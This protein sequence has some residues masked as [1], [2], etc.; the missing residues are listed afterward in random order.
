E[1]SGEGAPAGSADDVL[2]L[3]RARQRFQLELVGILR[4][5]R[6]G[7]RMRTLARLFRSLGERDWGGGQRLLWDTSGTLC[8]AVAMDGLACEDRVRSCLREIDNEL[9][10]FIALEAAFRS[11]A[12]SDS[13][14][15]ALL[16][17]LADSRPVSGPVVAL[18]QK[19]RLIPGP[20]LAESDGGAAT[21]RE[22]ANIAAISRELGR[23]FERVEGSGGDS[24]AIDTVLR[25]LHPDLS[26]IHGMLVAGEFTP[27]ATALGAEL[28]R[29]GTALSPG[30]DQEER[31]TEI[32]M[33]LLE[34]DQRLAA[35]AV[36]A[37][38]PEAASDARRHPL[39]LARETVCREVQAG[40]EQAKQAVADYARSGEAATALTALP[41]ILG[42]LVGALRLTGLGG[43]ESILSACRA[44][45][46]DVLAGRCAAPDSADVDR[47]ADGLSS[48]EYFLERLLQ[49]GEPSDLIL[50]RSRESIGCLGQGVIAIPPRGIARTPA[51]PEPLVPEPLVPAP[52]P[53]E[54]ALPELEA[55]LPE[56]AGELPAEY[57]IEE[58]FDE[59]AAEAIRVEPEA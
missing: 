50:A 31:L 47:L 2:L 33:T 17:A 5:D 38:S 16:T 36:R 6:V 54:E 9:R 52:Q 24:G 58:L 8:E 35:R 48:V 40:I 1:G 10:A 57:P 30:M 59:P 44:Y 42:G 56:L 21:V 25:E 23:I 27:E 39:V 53:A 13:L 49:D 11:R 22:I 18:Q 41:A 43:A 55:E 46:G 34:V 32:T 51:V 7:E 15:R 26:Q 20:G 45:L 14:Y 12:P 28:T 29:L 4:E 37:G 3:R 19:Y